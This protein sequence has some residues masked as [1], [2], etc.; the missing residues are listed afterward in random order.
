M[1]P[2]ERIE[3]VRDITGGGANVVI[4]CANHPSSSVEGMQQARKLGTFVEIGN[5]GARGIEQTIDVGKVV[6][7]RNVKVTSVV[8]NYPKTFDRA[9]RLLKRHHELPFARLITHRF[10]RLE[11]LL[12]TMKK[13]SDDDYLKGVYLPE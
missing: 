9:F 2:D 12:P 5:A 11:D 7:A 4:N 8:A 6:F 13:M 10:N 1:T 3:K